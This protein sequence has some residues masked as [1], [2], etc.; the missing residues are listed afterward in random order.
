[1]EK[2]INISE[3]PLIISILSG[4]GGVGKSVITYN[5]ATAAAGQGQRCLIIDCDWYF[6]NIHILA[7]VLPRLNLAD[8]VYNESQLPEALV[9]LDDRLHLLPSPASPISDKEP[10][11]SDIEKFLRKG[12]T[13]FAAYDLILLDTPCSLLGLIDLCADISDL[14]LIIVNPELTS[15]ADGY[16]LFKYLTVSGYKNPVYL[17]ANQ[18]KD[19]TEYEYIYRK[20]SALSERFLQKRPLDGGYVIDDERVIE[21][22]ERQKSLF[23][24]AADSE[25]TEQFL[26]LCKLLTENNLENDL[27]SQIEAERS[28]NS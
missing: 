22:V 13:L 20:F 12:K 14:N 26:K 1:M 21:S 17:L 8:I 23:E 10:N 18:V 9:S 11:R 2:R 16:G 5:L 3:K 19:G 4:K 24:T 28:I 15:I 6:G 25:V 27:S 7:N